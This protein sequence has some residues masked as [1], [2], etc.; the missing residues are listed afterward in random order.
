MQQPQRWSRGKINFLQRRIRSFLEHKRQIIFEWQNAYTAQHV[1]MLHEEKRLRTKAFQDEYNNAP[2]T[3][4][5]LATDLDMGISIQQLCDLYKVRRKIHQETLFEY[6][7]ELAEFQKEAQLRMRMRLAQKMILGDRFDIEATLDKEEADGK[8][9]LTAPTKPTLNRNVHPSIY[10]MLIKLSS[11]AMKGK[12]T[13]EVTQEAVY[14]L[15]DFRM[16]ALQRQ[17]EMHNLSHSDLETSLQKIELV[18]KR[19]R[20]DTDSG[21][22]KV[23]D[24]APQ[25]KVESTNLIETTVLNDICL[26]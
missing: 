7:R 12:V 4:E 15:H 3:Q 24:D 5:G 8:L 9:P 14:A 6:K 19:H 16:A 25:I 26:E 21:D 17:A 18:K 23:D 20:D 22:H 13:F 2:A 10:E 1:R 11:D